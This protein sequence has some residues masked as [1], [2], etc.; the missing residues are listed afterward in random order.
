MPRRSRERLS[1]SK[2]DIAP[3]ETVGEPEKADVGLLIPIRVDIGRLFPH[4]DVGQMSKQEWKH[5]LTAAV[6]LGADAIAHSR[7]LQ[8]ALG[9]SVSPRG[10]NDYLAE[11]SP[12]AEQ[13]ESGGGEEDGLVDLLYQLDG[14][15]E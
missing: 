4:V 1:P 11:S 3:T 6:R 12:Q 9:I 8:V 5:I 13:S 15:E 10:H 14:Q 7:Q 2:T